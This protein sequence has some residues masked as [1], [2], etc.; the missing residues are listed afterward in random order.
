MVHWVN[1]R[2]KFIEATAG[3]TELT[4]RGVRVSLEREGEPFVGRSGNGTGLLDELSHGAE[5]TLGALRQLVGQDISLALLTIGPV[6][7]LGQNF[8]LAVVE[9]AFKR[10]T[11][12]VLGV[13][14]RTDSPARDGALA[15]LQATNRILGLS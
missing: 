12:T 1:R 14:P 2:V 11:Y 9:V 6:V 7:A 8:V 4:G 15:V 10:A 13:C 5:A 3:Q